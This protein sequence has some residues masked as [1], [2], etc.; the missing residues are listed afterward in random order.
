MTAFNSQTFDQHLSSIQ[1]SWSIVHDAKL[2]TNAVAAAREKLLRR[3]RGAVYRYLL[4]VV[5]DAAVAD[6]LTQDFALKFTRGD[7][8]TADPQ[9]G[10]FRKFVKTAVLNLVRDHHRKGRNRPV[11]LPDEEALP[12]DA[13]AA[14]SPEQQFVDS[15]KQ[16]LLNRAW[17]ALKAQRETE[18]P[19]F[20]VLQFRSQNADLRS[21]ELAKRLSD[22]LGREVTANWVRQVL[23]RARNKFAE[24]LL[25]DVVHSLN[26]PTRDDVEAELRETGLYE[27]CAPVLRQS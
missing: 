25:Q 11:K 14:D 1:T 18:L 6:D 12:V 21:A 10:R 4:A 16:E 8:R 26:A 13:A 15:W 7:F 17:S 2:G 22:V 20:D 24:L 27:Y 19:L 23:F 3:Y 5:K 9:R